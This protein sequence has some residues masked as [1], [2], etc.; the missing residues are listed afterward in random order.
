MIEKLTSARDDTSS[1][2]QEKNQGGDTLV[3]V[4]PN[5]AHLL[6]LHR[7]QLPGLSTLL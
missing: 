3:T 1:D 6:R 4:H 2:Q 7:W 5:R